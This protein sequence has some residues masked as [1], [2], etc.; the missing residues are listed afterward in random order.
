LVAVLF[1]VTS[2]TV[3][4]KGDMMSDGKYKDLNAHQRKVGDQIESLVKSVFILSGTSLTISIGVFNSPI[5]LQLSTE[6]K[7]A[8]KIS[9]VAF[10]TSIMVLVI[11]LSLIVLENYRFGTHWFDNLKST[12]PRCA[13]SSNK[14]VNLIPILLGIGILLFL[15]GMSGLAWTALDILNT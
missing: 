9:W 14:V 4:A 5:A 7:C 8:L 11:S 6:A 13:E 15:L 2:A 12:E 3:M 1:G 10:L